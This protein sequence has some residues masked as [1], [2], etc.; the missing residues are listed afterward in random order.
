MS[1][2][3][4]R[5]ASR[6][7]TSH[8]EANDG[9]T[10]MRSGRAFGLHQTQRCRRDAIERAGRVPEDRPHPLRV[11]FSACPRRSNKTNAQ[12]VFEL[13]D[14]MT[15][16]RLRHAQL[17]GSAGKAQVLGRGLESTQRT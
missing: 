2:C 4:A 15:D 12:P 10:V 5:N 17:G 14:L 9:R 3:K 1:G 8:R 16:G 6:R 13:A 11:S 7:G